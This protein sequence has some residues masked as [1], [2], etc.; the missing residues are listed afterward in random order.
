MR[1]VRVTI[2]GEVYERQVDDHRTLVHFL[3]D[4]LGLTGTK[5]G[6]SAGECGACTVLLNGETVNACLVLAAE[7]D[8]AFIETIEGESKSGTMSAV[9]KAFE[10]N[11]SAQCGFCIPGMIMSVKRLLQR[12]PKP[13]EHEIKEGIEGNFCR[14]TGYVQIIEAVQDLTGQLKRSARGGKEGLRRV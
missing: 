1:S 13:T 10:K 7:C 2:N 6:C 14:C 5:E 4:D 12:H 3:H 8:G 9:Q 11:H